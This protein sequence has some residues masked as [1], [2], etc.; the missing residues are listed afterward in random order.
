MKNNI[1]FAERRLVLKQVRFD[2]LEDIEKQNLEFFFPGYAG[3]GQSIADVPSDSPLKVAEERG[4]TIIRDDNLP[5]RFAGDASLPRSRYHT[6]CT[7]IDGDD[8]GTLLNELMAYSRVDKIGY[9]SL[10]DSTEDNET[11]Q[12]FRGFLVPGGK[13][14]FC[15]PFENDK[16]PSVYRKAFGVGPA[17]PPGSIIAVI[18]L[19]VTEETIDK[20]IDLREPV[21]QSWFTRELTRLVDPT[22]SKPCFPVA[23]HLDSFVDLL[24]SLLSQSL[25]DNRRVTQ[26]AGL[27]LRRLGANALIFPSVRSN[28]STDIS[29]HELGHWKGWNMVD[30]R[31]SPQPTIAGTVDLSPV[32]EK[33]PTFGG[34]SLLE[35]SSPIEYSATRTEQDQSGP[36]AGS[37]HVQGLREQREHYYQFMVW[38]FYVDQIQ[39][40]SSDN[41]GKRL[42]DLVFSLSASGKILDLRRLGQTSSLFCAAIFGDEDAKQSL[43]RLSESIELTEGDK[44]IRAFLDIL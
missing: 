38:K 44:T 20:V 1:P 11:A 40:K 10:I 5:R 18:P 3:G 19:R 13:A 4:F 42:L 30:Y 21:V 37:I 8:G 15:V 32:W 24:P 27:W 2:L 36:K 22:T 6:V 29:D 25:G 14:V 33:Y 12:H 28:A 31:G 17:H 39:S 34:T 16:F 43:V 9:F 35:D 41:L 23:G 26:T 7:D